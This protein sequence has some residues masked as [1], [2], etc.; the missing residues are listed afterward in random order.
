MFLL[1]GAK[2]LSRKLRIFVVYFSDSKRAYKTI[3]TEY[4]VK[5]EVAVSNPKA[6]Q[7]VS[8][9]RRDKEIPVGPERERVYAML[10]SISSSVVE[11]VSLS[12]VSTVEEQT[13]D[14]REHWWK[15]GFNKRAFF[16]VTF[17]SFRVS[18]KSVNNF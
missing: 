11:P 13:M 15:M 12:S 6:C 16:E 17:P 7:A 10:A 14:E 4:G 9:Y 8:S 5:E 2:R 18:P 1:K 3:A